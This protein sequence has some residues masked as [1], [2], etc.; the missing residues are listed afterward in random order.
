MLLHPRVVHRFAVATA[1]ATY[2]LILIGGLV[3]GT[4]SSLA[5]PDWPTCYGS[6]MPKMEG[7][8]L[9]EHSHRLAAGT[10]VILTLVLAGLLTAA[11][12]ASLR[13]LRPFGWLAVGL[14]IVQALLGGITVKLRLPTPISTAHTGTSLLF[15]LTLVYIAVR[16]RPLPVVAPSVPPP[17]VARMA[18]IAAVAIYF[19]MLLG[20]LVRHS[21]AALACTDVPLCRG[22]L[23]P[24]AHPTVLIQALHRLTGVAVA[25]LVFASSFVTLRRAWGRAG[26]RTL[27]IAAPVLVCVQIA[28]G[29]HAVT[30]FL[31]LATVE[32]HLA[33]ATALLATQVLIVLRADV[34]TAPGRPSVAWFRSMVSLGKPRI[35]GLV[36]VTFLGGLWLAPGEIA[37]WRTMM[38]LIGTA[39]LVAASNA[40]NMYIE[41]DA[42]ALM[43]RTRD[44]PLPR[45]VVSPEAALAFGTGLACVGI[46]LVF[47][48]SNLLTGLLGLLAI[49]GYVAVYTPLK[50]HSGAALFVGAVPG[51]LPPLMG[52]T[53]VTGQLYAPGLALFGVLFLW[54]IPH[55][56]AIATYRAADYARGGFKVLPLT[57]PVRATRAIMLVFSVGLVAVTIALEP[58][59]VAGPR[60]ALVAALLGTVFI[61]WAAAGFRRAAE[62]RWA[63]S[64]FLYSLVYLTLLFV[65]L[66]I[67]RTVA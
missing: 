17:A 20:G 15:F 64:L 43:E 9:V 37:H 27:A 2:L 1:V 34:A 59:R 65:A 12:D 10:V 48:G 54:Q 21:G 45:A 24:D 33:V 4:G 38:T 61:G 8:V 6:F 23:W 52:W 58:L 5:C 41:R 32:S 47:L 53:A 62:N 56:L 46:A 14:V 29:L 50:R 22:S 57:V 30:S 31:D 51:A 13:P 25:L 55:F 60:Y 28:L 66:A 3:H 63:R 49:G 19:Q 39:L 67:D 7:G 18:L 36:V 42:D 35:T 44:R 16:S 26:L 40:L 11:R